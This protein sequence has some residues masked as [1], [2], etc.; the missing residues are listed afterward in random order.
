MATAAAP[1][2]VSPAGGLVGLLCPFLPYPSVPA[3]SATIPYSDHNTGRK[4]EPGSRWLWVGVG[5]DAD[6]ECKLQAGLATLGNSV[7]TALP[8][9]LSSCLGHDSQ[10]CTMRAR[11]ILPGAGASE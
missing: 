1:W 6:L 5:R 2:G 10:G 9:G 7:S 11:G 3:F 4:V 8:L